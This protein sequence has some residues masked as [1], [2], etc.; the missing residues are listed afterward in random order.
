MALLFGKKLNLLNRARL[1]DVCFAGGVALRY[2]VLVYSP[3]YWINYHF[4]EKHFK[5]LNLDVCMIFNVPN[6]QCQKRT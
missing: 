6:F 5:Y 2:K 3:P 4:L 1:E